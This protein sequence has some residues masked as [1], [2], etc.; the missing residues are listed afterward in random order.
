MRRINLDMQSIYSRVST[1]FSTLRF[2]KGDPAMLN[3]L[4]DPLREELNTRTPY[5]RRRYPAYLQGYAQGL[6]D[7]EFKRILQHEVEFCYRH[8]DTKVIYSTHMGSS[9]RSTEEFYDRKAGSEL[10]NYESAHVWKGTDKPFGKW[11]PVWVNRGT[12]NTEEKAA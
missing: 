1:A 4:L 11:E 2:S 7:A 9:H 12:E 3:R 6:T 10:N 8:P 5:G